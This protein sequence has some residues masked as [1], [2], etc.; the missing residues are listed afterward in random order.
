MN[1]SKGKIPQWQG[2][3]TKPLLS[4]ESL[5]D[6]LKELMGVA[7]YTVNAGIFKGKTVNRTIIEALRRPKPR[8]LWRELW[9]EGELCILFADTNL[10]KSIL[11]VEIADLIS[12]KEKVI[13]FDFELSDKQFQI[14][15]SDDMGNHYQFSDNLLRF[16]INTDGI[17]TD[18]IEKQ[19]N[20]DMKKVIETTGAK[21]VIVDNLTYLSVETEKSKS[22]LPLMKSLKTLKRKYGLSI[23]CLAHTPK[24]NLSNPITR[25]DLAGSKTIIN[26]CDSAVAIG[27]SARDKSVRYVKQIKSRNSEIVY[28][29]ENIILYQILKKDD[30]FLKFEFIGYGIEREHLKEFSDNEMEERKKKVLEMKRQNISN[31]KIA[32]HFLVTE[33]TIRDWLKKYD[34]VHL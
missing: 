30:N 24:R 33:K 26:F 27:E 12:Q 7:E 2:N 23:L 13:Y 15:Y 6:K 5:N 8:E 4:V 28:D 9:Y 22:A 21:I 10:G 11:A 29:A 16:E 32:E 20:E 14:R 19:I 17:T 1:N 25:N 3:K 18:D 31:R 34:Y